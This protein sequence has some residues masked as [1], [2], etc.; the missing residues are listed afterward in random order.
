MFAH[1]LGDFGSLLEK[2][3]FLGRTLLLRLQGYQTCAGAGMLAPGLPNAMLAQHLVL[4]VFAH[5]FVD[6]GGLLEK[7]LFL[8]R[9]LLLRLQGYQTCVGAGML[10]SGLANAV[11]A[12][13]FVLGVFAHLVSDFGGLLKKLLFLGRTLLLR[14]WGSKP[15]VVQEWWLQG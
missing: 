4:G 7:H 8:G 6:F 9:T 14:L 1:L 2:H 3:L 15:V 5:L 10:A 13:H 11:L 12:Q